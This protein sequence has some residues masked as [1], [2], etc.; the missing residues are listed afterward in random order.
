[1]KRN[2]I[3]TSPGGK[4]HGVLVVQRFIFQKQMYTCANLAID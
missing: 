1:M 4:A 3:G 2:I